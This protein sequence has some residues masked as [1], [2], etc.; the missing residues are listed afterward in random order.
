M[1]NETPVTAVRGAGAFTTSVVATGHEVTLGVSDIIARDIGVKSLTTTGNVSVGGE[2][3]SFWYN[4]NFK[5]RT[6][7]N[8][9]QYNWN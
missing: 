7:F 1:P 6:S 3:Y 2:P 8:K 5:Y 9:R 4:H